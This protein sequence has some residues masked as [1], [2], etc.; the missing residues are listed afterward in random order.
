MIDTR[1][2]FVTQDR[3]K[4]TDSVKGAAARESTDSVIN[5]VHASPPPPQPSTAVHAYAL[6]C[7]LFPWCASYSQ[8]ECLY[9]EIR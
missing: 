4:S 9:I 3:E 5:F 6:T 7:P 8:N 1:T 2:F